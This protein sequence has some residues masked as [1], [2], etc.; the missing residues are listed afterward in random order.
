MPD[1]IF[2]QRQR[3]RTCA[4]WTRRNANVPPCSKPPPACVQYVI[5]TS[6]LHTTH[7]LCPRGLCETALL[8]PPRPMSARAEPRRPRRAID[9]ARTAAA[10]TLKNLCKDSTTSRSTYSALTPL[11]TRRPTGTTGD[12]NLH[13]QRAQLRQTSPAAHTDSPKGSSCRHII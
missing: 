11:D 10:A 7:R 8:P 13:P 1:V 9:R 6:I 4:M 3:H 12:V 2:T 5:V